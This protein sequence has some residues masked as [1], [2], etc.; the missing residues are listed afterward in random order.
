LTGV[1]FHGDAPSLLGLHVFEGDY[2]ATV[3]FLS[4]TTGWDSIYGGRPTALWNL[5]PPIRITDMGV[6]TNHFGFNINGT[7]GQSITV[8]AS[9]NVSNPIWTPVGTNAL[10]GG[11]SYF[12]DPQ[13]TNYPQRSYRLR[14]P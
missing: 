12:S 3:F 1:N 9:T 6:L 5:P 10:I 13:W 7:G 8:E 2:K 14:S 11:S 4:N